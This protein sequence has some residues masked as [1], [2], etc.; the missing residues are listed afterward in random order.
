MAFE[1]I[2]KN[3]L[4]I[5]ILHFLELPPFGVGCAAVLSN[6]L[7]LFLKDSNSLVFSTLLLKSVASSLEENYNL[8]VVSE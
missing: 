3:Y 1:N 6:N 2:S 4:N 5:Q 8:P 7:A